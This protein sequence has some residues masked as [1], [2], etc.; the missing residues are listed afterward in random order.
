MSRTLVRS[1]SSPLALTTRAFAVGA[2]SDSVEARNRVP[3]RAPSAPSI[4]DAARPRP[5]AMPPAATTRTFRPDRAATGGAFDRGNARGTES[6]QTTGTAAQKP[7]ISGA[8]RA[9]RGIGGLVND[10]T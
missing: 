9:L 1:V 2:I 5:S 8:F 4:R 10:T 6:L 3:I 7:W